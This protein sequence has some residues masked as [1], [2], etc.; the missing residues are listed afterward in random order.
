LLDSGGDERPA[1][2]DACWMIPPTQ[3]PCFIQLGRFG[4]LILLF[5]AFKAIYDRTGHKPI[6]M[7][8][9]EYA[10]VFDG[11]LY[12]KPFPV[13]WH[14]W[15]GIPEARRL[16]EEQ[17]GGAII[18]QWWHESPKDNLLDQQQ[19]GGTVLQCH[20]HEWG[21]NVERWPNFMTSMWERA[22][23]TAEEMRTLPLVFDLRDLGRERLLRESVHSRQGKPLLL[24]NFSGHSSP[25]AW[26]PEVMRAVNQ[27]QHQFNIVDIGR[28]KA[29]RI[30]DLLGLFDAAA[31]L[32]TIDTAT[33]HLAAG[34][35][36]PYIAYTRADWSA[37]VPKG[38][39]VLEIK[40]RDEEVKG[41]M[42]E[43]VRVLETW[44][45]SP[46]AQPKAVF[47]GK[48]GGGGVLAV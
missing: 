27:F 37:S 7:V 28:L 39:C 3:A 16:A 18:P 22:G 26:V 31:G 25:F 1:M 30:Y 40:Y 6:V 17:F 36:V 2:K 5:P 35:A 8:S 10:S 20:G 9:T 24:V 12:A 13:H 43:V 42:G 41:R 21:I 32:I 11:I 34:S 46:A 14:W 29:Q 44:A 33:L 45:Q 19:R 47:S 4:D 15:Q 48:G 23:F 38:N